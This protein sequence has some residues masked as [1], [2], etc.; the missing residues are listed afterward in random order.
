MN[1]WY[2]KTVTKAVVLIIA[3]ISGGLLITSLTA[4]FTLAGTSDPVRIY[5]TATQ[6]YEDSEDFNIAVQDLMADV[7]RQNRLKNLFETDGTY[8]PDK[9]VDVMR[10]S[11]YGTISGFNESGL[12]Y[13]LEELESWS[14][15]YTAGE[16]DMYD[17][18]S[19][20]VCEETDGNYHYYYLSEF[21]TLLDNGQLRMEF[22]EDGQN[23]GE[24]LRDLEE[25][26]L[27]SSG[28]YDFRIFDSEGY[29]A[30]YGLLEFRAGA[31]RKICTGRGGKSAPGSK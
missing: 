22:L 5:E 7:M 26:L 31:K 16:G 21:L 29:H 3:M 10:Y 23:Q 2:R 17:S 1:Q 8:N 24:F 11:K 30:L 20:I 28:Y 14:E 9:L 19:V 12:A 18:N 6:P 27:T 4:A 13:T 15:D 25:G